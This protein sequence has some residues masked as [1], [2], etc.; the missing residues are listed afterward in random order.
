MSVNEVAEHI[1]LI[2]CDLQFLNRRVQSTCER[3]NADTAVV[4]DIHMACTR[5]STRTMRV[6]AYRH[7]VDLDTLLLEVLRNKVGGL[8]RLVCGLDADDSHSP[9]TAGELRTQAPVSVS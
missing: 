6:V 5:T 9:C 4:A 3:R 8:R 1:G 2:W 7:G